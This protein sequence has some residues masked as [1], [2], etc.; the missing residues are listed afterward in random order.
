MKLTRMTRGVAAATT[1]ALAL[2]WTAPASALTLV[3]QC[4]DATGAI[5]PCTTSVPE[6]ATLSLLGLAVAGLA[7]ARRRR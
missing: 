2:V 7:L 3:N 1:S 5:V 4:T 6:P